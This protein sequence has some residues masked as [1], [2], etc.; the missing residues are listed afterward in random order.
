MK[1]PPSV[2]DSSRPISLVGMPLAGKSTAARLLAEYLNLPVRSTDAWVEAHLGMPVAAIFEAKGEMYFRKKER[3]ALEAL[4]R[5]NRPFVLD[6]GGGLPCFYDNMDVLNQ[7][8]L[9]VWLD[10]PVTALAQRSLQ[11]QGRPLLKAL[12]DNLKKREIFLGN[13]RFE[14]MPYYGKAQWLWKRDAGAEFWIKLNS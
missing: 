8:T 11:Q 4:L 2:S 7:T 9:T 13:L 1:L 3:E 14:R 12:P 6:T 10:V 5:E